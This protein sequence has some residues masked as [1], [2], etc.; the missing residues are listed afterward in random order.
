MVDTVTPEERVT[1]LTLAGVL[2]GFVEEFSY[3]PFV[4]LVHSS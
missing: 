2:D 4:L 3:F 1:L